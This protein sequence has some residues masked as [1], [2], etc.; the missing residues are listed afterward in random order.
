MNFKVKRIGSVCK[1]LQVPVFT[2]FQQPP[3]LKMIVISPYM[4]HQTSIL[5]LVNLQCFST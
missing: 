2:C 4:D 1:E 5:Y 3:R